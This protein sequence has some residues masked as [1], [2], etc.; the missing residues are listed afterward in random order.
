MKTK[1]ILKKKEVKNVQKKRQRKRK[2]IE[3]EQ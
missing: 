2:I 3:N 1:Q